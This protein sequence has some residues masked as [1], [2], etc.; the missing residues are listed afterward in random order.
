MFFGQPSWA[1]PQIAFPPYGPWPWRDW[2][3]P[4]QRASKRPTPPRANTSSCL[5]M[6]C[7]QKYATSG[8]SSPAMTAEDPSPLVPAALF[9]VLLGQKLRFS[10]APLASLGALHSTR[11][12]R[13]EKTLPHTRLGVVPSL[14]DTG[15][16]ALSLLLRQLGV[17][18]LADIGLGVLRSYLRLNPHFLGNFGVVLNSL[19]QAKLSFAA[20]R[21]TDHP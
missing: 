8:Q 12:D 21:H 11:L 19:H 9:L 20:S 16:T 2:W 17:S 15:T 1:A 3:R 6:D 5:E 18:L 10:R 14:I 7:R 4:S 13:L